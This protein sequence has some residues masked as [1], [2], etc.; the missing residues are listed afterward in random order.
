MRNIEKPNKGLSVSIFDETKVGNI[1]VKGTEATDRTAISTRKM[2]QCL[3]LDS[4]FH[5]HILK[6][7]L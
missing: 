1:L 4:L 2:R 3:I 5:K 7:T 6:E